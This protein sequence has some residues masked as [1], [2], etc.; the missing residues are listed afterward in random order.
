MAQTIQI[1]RSTGSS[2]PSSLANGELA[3]LH[4]GSNKKLYIG[5]PG[6]ANGDISV[7]GG[8]DF[9]DK[10][11]LI[12]A[13]NGT[14]AADASVVASAN[15]LGVIRIGAG[16]SIATN[17]EVSA[18][19]VTATSVT[20]AGALMDSEVTNLAQVKAFSSADYAT[21]AQGTLATNALP[22]A[23]GTLTGD[24]SFG[25]NLKIKMGAQTG[26][27]L[28]IYH[29]GSDSIIEDRGNGNLKLIADDLE[30]KNANGDT[31]FQTNSSG[32]TVFKIA[33]DEILKVFGDTDGAV[34]AKSNIRINSL[35]GK[36][37]TGGVAVADS[38][39]GAE[40]CFEMF[41]STNSSNT[42]HHGNVK[43]KGGG[44]LKLTTD[45]TS[46]TQVTAG[47]FQLASGTDINEF[48]IDTDLAGNSDDAVPTEKA[49]K[50]YVD[51]KLGNFTLSGDT[52]STS[53]STVTISDA[54]TITGDLTVQGTTT[55]IDSSTV[56]FEDNV[57]LL[58]KNVTGTPSGQAGIE[59][60]RGT[61]VNAFIVW[62][63]TTDRWS[64]GTGSALNPNVLDTNTLSALN[65]ENIA[66]DGG[67]FS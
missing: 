35:N 33:S 27:D 13:A 57:L 1:K 29:D 38:G 62:N 48:S 30:V 22:K 41:G 7:I 46:K 47:K 28:N 59:V 6:G 31:F 2:A 40:Y 63:E 10:L 52:L 8:K 9:T 11:D 26:G 65:V 58:N 18:D 5:D 50:A 24:I 19:E 25:D 4:H 43:V 32:E 3:Y 17:G 60:E 21:A 64:I 16:L 66:I 20:N 14:N 34:R 44:D 37:Q 49:V 23:G 42:D 67:T 54:V 61:S 15:N 39:N 56:V 55:T 45:S 12:G 51:G 36:F 53:G